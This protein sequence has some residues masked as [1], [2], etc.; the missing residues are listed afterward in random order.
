MRARSL[1]SIL[2]VAVGVMLM[3][4]SASASSVGLNG[5]GR[6]P[7]LGLDHYALARPALSADPSTFYPPNALCL[8]HDYVFPTSATVTGT[9]LPATT[10]FSVEYH[11]K[12]ATT[13]KGVTTSEGG[14]SATVHDVSQPDGSYKMVAKAGTKTAATTVYS[15]GDT[16]AIAHGKSAA[17]HWSWQAV[18]FDAN[19]TAN[20]LISGSVYESKV[21]NASG[22]LTSNFV[23]A[24]PRTGTLELSFQGYFGGE[25]F[26]FGSGTVDCN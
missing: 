13:A 12:K 16:C 5:G 26:T 17:L 9:G 11:A 2:A 1:A 21:T 20:L 22:A 6:S 14:L 23:K 19:T 10:D 8:K 15:S 4:A 7:S 24:C 25:L 18:G 3:S